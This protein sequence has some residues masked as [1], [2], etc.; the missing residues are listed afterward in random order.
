MSCSYFKDT[1]EGERDI[2]LG[3]GAAAGLHTKK[4]SSPIYLSV[5]KFLIL[6]LEGLVFADWAFGVA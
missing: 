2:R 6:T 5:E 3:S 1:L 4:G